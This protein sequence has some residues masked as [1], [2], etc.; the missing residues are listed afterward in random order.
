MPSLAGFF[1]LTGLA[2][3]GFPG[4]VGF[5]AM[6]LLIEGAVEYYPLW[7]QRSLSQGL[8]MVSRFC[9]LIFES[10]RARAIA[11]PCPLDCGLLNVSP[12]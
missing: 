3:I 10:L 11:R 5:I 7:A 12:Y 6:E 8:V 9:E 4:T 2:S 1:L